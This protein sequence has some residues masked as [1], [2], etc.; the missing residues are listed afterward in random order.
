MAFS[1]S[2]DRLV[3]LGDL[4]NRGPASRAVLQRVSA[5]GDAAVSLLTK[6]LQK[7]A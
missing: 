6:S 1:P 4:V 5:L 3:L 2:R 7:A